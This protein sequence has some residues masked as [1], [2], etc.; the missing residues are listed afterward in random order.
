MKPYIHYLEKEKEKKEANYKEL[1][2]WQIYACYNNK[3][4]KGFSKQKI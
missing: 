3:V 2:H 1:M 4:N